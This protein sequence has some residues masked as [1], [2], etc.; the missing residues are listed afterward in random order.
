MKQL[1]SRVAHLVSHGFGV[2]GFRRPR[3]FKRRALSGLLLTQLLGCMAPTSVPPAVLA[4]QLSVEA[5][6]AARA[7]LKD[8]APSSFKMLHQVVAK[9]QGQSYLMSGYMLGRKDGSFRVSASA[10]VG[11]K[12]FDVSKV[13]GRW[14]SQVY[15]QPL[16]E[17]LDATNVG[18]SVERIYFLP[19]TGPLRTDAGRW[20]ARSPIHGEEEIDTVEDWLDGE[21]LALRRKR[22]F[23]GGRQVVQVDYDK[24][25]LVQGTWLARSV[26]LTDGRGFSLELNVTG[27]EPGFPVSDAALRVRTS[28]S[29]D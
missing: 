11:P 12:L 8:R 10:S 24:L 26:L 7:T 18:R 2:A 29:S 17:R 21:T 23:K 15:L 28:A 6:E 13:D 4:P 27:Y 3:S 22:Y 20:V 1:T 5:A 16:A 25:E 19:A 14:E 9:Y